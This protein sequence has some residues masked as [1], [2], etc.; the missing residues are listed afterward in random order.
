MQEV[1]IRLMFSQVVEKLVGDKEI[2]SA[3][4]LASLFDNKITLICDGI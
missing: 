1:F 3:G 4:T 2:D